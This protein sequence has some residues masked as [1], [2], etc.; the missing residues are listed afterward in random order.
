MTDGYAG[1]VARVIR[2]GGRAMV[3]LAVVVGLLGFAFWR[4]PTAFM[5]EEDQGYYMTAFQLPADATAERTREAVM[6]LERHIATRPAIK[7]NEAILGF[8]FSGAGPNAAIA[9][10]ILKDW[11]ERGGATVKDEVGRTTAAMSA[12]K[13]G[14]IMS[15]VPPPLTSLAIHRVLPC[16][17]RTGPDAATPHWSRPRTSCWALRRRARW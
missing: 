7:G 6:T 15:L 16:G 10:T 5:P 14:I 3:A 4:L 9:F 11:G 17:W 8:G 13:E 1:W 12:I 2:R